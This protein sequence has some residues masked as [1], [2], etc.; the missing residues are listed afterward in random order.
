[1]NSEGA[2]TRRGRGFGR[3]FC[4]R[5]L[6]LCCFVVQRLFVLL[7]LLY[8]GLAAEAGPVF[9]TNAT[10]VAKLLAAGDTWLLPQPK[11]L[12]LT[13]GSFD[14]KTCKGI[15]LVGCD[16]A[17]L[18]TDFPALLQERC[19]VRLKATVGKPGRG[20]IS[21]VLCPQE[22]LPLGVKSLTPQ[23]LAGL[24]EQGYCLRVECSG[25]TAGAATEQGLYYA[26]RTL[27]QIAN[28]RTRLPGMVIRDWPSLRWRGFQYDISRGQMPK[29]ASL[30]RLAAITAEAK[31]NMYE[32]YIEHVFQWERYPDI[33][34][35]E[36]LSHAEAREL[37]DYAA[38]YHMDV[39]PLMQTFGHFYNIGTK[40][41]YRKFMV[42]DGGT[43]DIRKP[44]AVAFVT[45]LIDE[46]CAAFP[47][48]F[49]NV[50]ITEI[51]DAAFKKTGTTQA[52]LNELTF[53][54]AL[55]IREAA[56]RHG[57]RLMIAQAQLSAEGSLAGLGSVAERLPKDILISDYYTAE[58]YGGWE[59]DFPRLQKL[60]LDFFVQPWIDSHGHIMPYVGHAMD[61]SDIE[62]SRGLQYGAV[63]STTCDWGDDGHYHLPA[64]TWFPFVYH[65]AS[66]WTGA[67]LDRDYFNQAFCRLVFG[68]GDD[69]IARAILLAGNINGQKLK[70]RNAA[71]GI[72][73]PAYSG[74]S[75]FGR[76]YYE[77][78][79]D[80]FS[81]PKVLDIVEPGRKGEEI[82]APA[83]EAEKLL[84]GARG[85][86]QRNQDALDRLLFSARNYEA[87]GRKLIARGHFLDHNIPRA[88]VAE[89]LLALAKTYEDLKAD[90][91]RLWLADCMDAGS[92][93]GYVQRFDNTI[94]PCRKKAEE[95]AHKE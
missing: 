36:A 29:L 18:Q 15:R 76:Y 74:N 51:D 30:K 6:R 48:K 4:L 86:V 26:A 19:G 20:C 59:K 37:F 49:L 35:P 38:R 66:A 95:L 25:I 60:G 14:L 27:A 65:A 24:G 75:T 64:V 10:N 91:Q 12:A 52:E 81:D 87:M 89:E 84:E 93:R 1:M 9:E 23:D 44:E 2:K 5:T 94:V 50:D 33:A 42:E 70:L 62:I 83:L 82:L 54:Y 77:F 56:A 7:T 55:K 73:E 3:G 28:G 57:M 67:K 90:F 63:G 43:V 71:G 45:N 17:C 21:L 80:P 79:G 58:F 8:C 85:Q 34:P 88:Q 78:F 41:P 22:L 92:F 31:M 68:T 13:Q 39:H 72:D 61:F 53:Q 46:V 69:A 40:A 16:E 47:G 11:A 32:P